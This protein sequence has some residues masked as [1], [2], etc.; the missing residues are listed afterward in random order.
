MQFVL[1]WE[2]VLHKFSLC[3]WSFLF[4]IS[5]EV[6]LNFLYVHLVYCLIFRNYLKFNF[7]YMALSLVTFV[8]WLG[9]EQIWLEENL[10]F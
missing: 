6:S 9:D 7:N 5:L 10:S 3:L 8:L 2:L 4:G 1:L